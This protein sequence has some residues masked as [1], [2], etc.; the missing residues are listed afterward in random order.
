M[1]HREMNG[2]MIDVTQVYTN[3]MSLTPWREEQ[4]LKAATVRFA[5]FACLR[6]RCAAWSER[7]VLLRLTKQLAVHAANH[8][9]TISKFIIESGRKA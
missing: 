5:L 9:L 8:M 6:C 3:F 7:R 4:N 2:L 1:R